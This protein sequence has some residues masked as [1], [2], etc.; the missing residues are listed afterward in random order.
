MDNELPYD[1]DLLP[2]DFDLLYDV[3]DMTDVEM[4]A[5]GEPHRSDATPADLIEMFELL[6]MV[7]PICLRGNTNG[8][9]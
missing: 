9:A 7:V 1:F 4:I 6:G 2:Y 5:N 8:N 3:K